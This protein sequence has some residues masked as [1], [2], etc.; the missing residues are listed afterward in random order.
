MDIRNGIYYDPE[1]ELWVNPVAETAVISYQTMTIPI[2]TALSDIID[3]E[4]KSIKRIIFP[5]AW[6]A[7]DVSFLTGET[8]ATVSS[9]YKEDGTEVTVKA[10]ASRG[11]SLA[12][13]TPLSALS[14]FQIRSG[15]VATPVNQLAER[16]ITLVLV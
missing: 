14:F 11:I 15:V 3:L 9:I 10:A 8:S 2:N 4:G 7:A 12:N 6:T 16:K 1:R 5:S 13:P